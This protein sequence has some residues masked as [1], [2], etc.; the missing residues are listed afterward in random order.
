MAKPRTHAEAAAD[1]VLEKGLPADP[2]T[3]KLCLG[4][5]LVDGA[6]WDVLSSLLA[7]EDF[8]LEKHRRLFVAMQD[9]AARGERVDRVTLSSEV[10]TRGWLESVDGLAYIASLDE[11]LPDIVNLDVYA[12]IVLEK[13]HLRKVIFSAQRSIE[14][15]LSA[16]PAKDIAAAQ[17]SA[18]ESVQVGRTQE[19]DGKTVGQVVEAFPG[20][21]GVFLDPTLRKRGL[22]TGFRKLDEMLGGGLQDGELIILAAR[23]GVG[24][25]QPLDAL[26]K[27]PTGWIEMNSVKVGTVLASPDGN[28]SEVI[29][30]HPRGRLQTFL[31]KFSDG[32]EL[33]CCGDHLWETH[34]HKWW[35]GPTRIVST[36][37]LADAVTRKRYQRRV[38]IPLADGEFG[39]SEPLPIDPYVLGVL[40]GDGAITSA[41]PNVTT[42]DEEILRE[43][44]RRLPGV[45]LSKNGECGYRLAFGSRGGVQAGPNRLT[46]AL[47]NLGLWGKCSHQKFIPFPYL[48]ADRASRMDLLRGLMDTDGT[49]GKNNGSISYTTTSQRLA[50]DVRQL[51]WSIGAVCRKRSR[52][53]KYTSKG[54]RLSGKRSYTLTISYRYPRE[55]FGLARKKAISTIADRNDGNPARLTVLS[56]TPL[57]VTEV[58]CITVSHPRGLY[59]TN[60]YIVT[61]NSALALN[62]AQKIVLR[63]SEPKRV[64]FFSLEMS[65]ASLVTRMV[66]GEA[67]VSSS[68][69][70]AGYLSRDERAALQTALHFICES[71][72]RIHDEFRRTLQALLARI[73]AARKN[74]SCLTIIDY[75]Q[76]MVSGSKNENRNLEIGEMG[77]ALKLSALDLNMPILILSQIGRGAEKRAGGG[78]R[79]QLSDL[80]DSGTLEENADTV[81]SIFREEFYQKDKDN[82]KGLAEVDILKQRN[83]EL[84][85]IP[86][87]FLGQFIRFESRMEDGALPEVE[88][89]AAPEPP[90][91]APVRE[92]DGW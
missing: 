21:A 24:K 33:E 39:S 11:G 73:K 41:T 51:A 69:F 40:I 13:S 67:R 20:G 59:I 53:T 15:A 87:R 14:L 19:D 45:T 66:C 78:N 28:P 35:N 25:A 7:A 55:L 23:P 18:L 26:L 72:L 71:P 81:M 68:K 5:V 86:M 65:A 82:L 22:P 48:N 77:R 31:V 36:N 52:I 92:E 17:V 46:E 16:A 60:D 6:K 80:K 91:P 75:I 61:H 44:S 43:L 3:E 64:D 50:D 10:M 30:I 42:K 49:N 83:G 70:R 88:D 9:I 89:D 84:G 47:R 12:R 74:G 8:A 4:A 56:V 76:L 37:K 54:V 1:L 34:C 38:S 27:T 79:P 2:H 85:R 90:P 58:Q 29:A 32:R 63:R 57:R 62:I